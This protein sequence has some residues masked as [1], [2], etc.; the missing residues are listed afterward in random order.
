M[1]WTELDNTSIYSTEQVLSITKRT[2]EWVLWSPYPLPLPTAI[3]LN[4]HVLATL[5]GKPRTQWLSDLP[6]N[7]FL[8]CS[9]IPS[10]YAC[11]PRLGYLL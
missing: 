6:V 11:F 8:T 5:P 4:C 7:I 1:S 10:V 2:D 9:V 3:F